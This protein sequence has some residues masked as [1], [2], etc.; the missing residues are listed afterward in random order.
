M[1]ASAGLGYETRAYL[2]DAAWVAAEK[3]G[4]EARLQTA[5]AVEEALRDTP[6]YVSMETG[7]DTITADGPEGEIGLL[8]RYI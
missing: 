4:E 6:V 8:S 3:L 7:Q 2:V 5:P 1:L